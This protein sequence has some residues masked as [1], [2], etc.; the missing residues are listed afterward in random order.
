MSDPFHIMKPNCNTNG[1]SN[2]RLLLAD[3]LSCSFSLSCNPTY[4]DSILITEQDKTTME[5][6]T[7]NTP[8]F[9]QEDKPVCGAQLPV[10]FFPMLTAACSLLHSILPAIG[11]VLCRRSSSAFV[12]LIK[13]IDHVQQIN[14]TT[15]S[16]YNP[17]CSSIG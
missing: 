8:R 10:Q 2:T 14:E 6:Y 16:S 4:R 1:K 15:Y 11:S 17:Y 5:L 3:V 13:N 9:I 12:F 7:H